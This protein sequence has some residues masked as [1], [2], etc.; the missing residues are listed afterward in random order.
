MWVRCTVRGLEGL[1]RILMILLL[2]GAMSAQAGQ[3]Q[4]RKMGDLGSGPIFTF[5]TFCPVGYYPI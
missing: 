1:M 3:V 2:L 5:D 4:C